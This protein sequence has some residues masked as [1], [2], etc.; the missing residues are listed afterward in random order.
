MDLLLP[1]LEK[2]S[3]MQTICEINY[4][5]NSYMFFKYLFNEMIEYFLQVFLCN[6]LGYRAEIRQ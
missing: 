4:G 6:Y 2:P 5:K 1:M 3:N